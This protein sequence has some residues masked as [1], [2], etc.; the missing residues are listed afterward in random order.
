MREWWANTA[1]AIGTWAIVAA[2]VAFSLAPVF[3]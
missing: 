2:G 3:V 1:T